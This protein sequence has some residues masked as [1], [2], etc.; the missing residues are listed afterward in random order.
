MKL[1]NQM[2]AACLAGACALGA[3]APQD[4]HAGDAVMIITGT[5][6]SNNAHPLDSVAH[7]SVIVSPGDQNI[8]RLRSADLSDSQA[9]FLKACVAGSDCYTTIHS[10]LICSAP[11]GTTADNGDNNSSDGGTNP[12]SGGASASGSGGGAS[13]VLQI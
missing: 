8:A 2:K 1:G 12:S 9:K 6:A 13:S 10:D 5:M 3:A 7:K 4:A 11:G